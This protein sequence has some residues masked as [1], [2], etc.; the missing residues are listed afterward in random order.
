MWFFGINSDLEISLRLLSI[1]TI[2]QQLQSQSKT[3]SISKNRSWKIT[4]QQLLQIV[5]SQKEKIE[6]E[7]RENRSNSSLRSRLASKRSNT[8]S[9][10]R[11]LSTRHV[12]FLRFHKET[13]ASQWEERLLYLL[14]RFASI[15]RSIS[16]AQ[17]TQAREKRG[18]NKKKESVNREAGDLCAI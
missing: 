3:A 1:V 18:K 8:F 5:S 15:A 4:Q 17:Y 7:K 12:D 14:A 6:D 16:S 2:K 9:G 13:I 10:E 11:K